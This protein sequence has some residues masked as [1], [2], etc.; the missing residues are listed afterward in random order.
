MLIYLFL[1]YQGNLLPDVSDIKEIGIYAVAFALTRI[2]LEKTIFRYFAN[3]LIA[4]RPALLR[5]FM[6]EARRVFNSF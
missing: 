5:T 4:H 1:H 6:L 2:V 3:L